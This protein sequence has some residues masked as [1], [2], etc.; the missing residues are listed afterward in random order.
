[1]GIKRYIISGIIF[2]IAISIYAFSLVSSDYRIEVMNQVFIL[3]TALWVAMPAIII[4]VATILHLW[5]YAFKSYLNK[6]SVI[7][8]K[9]TFVELVQNSLS[10]QETTKQFKSDVFKEIGNIVNQLSFKIKSSDF[11]CDNQSINS[12]AQKIYQI[13]AGE[14]VSLKEFKL[15]SDSELVIKNN[16]NKTKVDEDY[17]LDIVKKASSND[18]SLVEAAF[19]KVLKTKSFTTVQKLLEDLELNKNMTIELLITDSTYED[20]FTLSNSEIVELVKKVELSKED[21]LRIAK[22]YTNRMGPDQIIKLFEDISS[23]NELATEA[24]LYVLFEYEMIDTV[25]EIVMNSGKD[26]YL[27]YKALLDLKDHGKH[28]NFENICYLK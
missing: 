5:Y 23:T 10:G 12:L 18:D 8:D 13:E 28:Y 20:Q 2:I 24:Y 16:I 11:E 6:R 17:A 7:K 26:D 27:P 4:F 15:P 1:M 14:Y 25:R 22:K 19:S 3:P 21:F 9:E